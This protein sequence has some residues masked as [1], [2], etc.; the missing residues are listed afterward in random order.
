VEAWASG[1]P[2]VSTTIGAEGLRCNAG[3]HLLL[4]DDPQEFAEAVAFLIDAP[5]ARAQLGDAGRRL[6]ESTYTWEAA[7]AALEREFVAIEDS[8]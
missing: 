6:Y 3:E 4:C 8:H 1:T 5:E 2:V 7:W